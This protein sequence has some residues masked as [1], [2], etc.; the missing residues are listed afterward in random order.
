MEY[1][2]TEHIGFA[3]FNNFLGLDELATMS[4]VN[5]TYNVMAKREI[6][7]IYQIIEKIRKSKIQVNTSSLYSNNF[8]KPDYTYDPHYWYQLFGRKLNTQELAIYYAYFISKYCMSGNKWCCVAYKDGFIKLLGAQSDG[9]VSL[10]N[11]EPEIY[12]R[13]TD[14]YRENISI[15]CEETWK[16]INPDIYID[17]KLLKKIIKHIIEKS[18]TKFDNQTLSYKTTIPTITDAIQY[19]YPISL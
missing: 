16:N 4:M 9:S 19:L 15:Q 13:F 1:Y 17:Q 8:G 18:K 2:P 10:S 12:I 6:K 11:N 7:K 3:I 14:Y 5:K